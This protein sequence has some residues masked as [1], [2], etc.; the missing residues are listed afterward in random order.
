MNDRKYFLK[1]IIIMLFIRESLLNFTPPESTIYTINKV[2]EFTLPGY[3]SKE[4]V[5]KQNWENIFWQTV[6]S[7]S[8]R[9]DNSE[10]NYYTDGNG[11][12]STPYTVIKAKKRLLK[13]INK[14]PFI[15]I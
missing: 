6:P 3:E 10:Q 8:S 2:K 12:F 9:D 5:A 15:Y 1:H 11:Q 7:T 14:F 4:D 13:G